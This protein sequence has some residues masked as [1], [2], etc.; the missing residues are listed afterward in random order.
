MPQQIGLKHNTTNDLSN[1]SPDEM[2]K[3]INSRYPEI[4]MELV[5][6]DRDRIHV[7]IKDASYLSES[8][9]SSGA[10]I[11][12]AESTYALTE[13]KGIRSVEFVFE[14]G[15]HAAPGV[16]SRADFDSLYTSSKP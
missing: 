12:M 11:Y 14:E 7:K 9:G 13:F 3:A 16:Y 1:V 15:D 6:K 2:V 8:M 5:K 10:Q 4:Q